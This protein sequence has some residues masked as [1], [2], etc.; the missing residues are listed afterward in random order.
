MISYIEIVT[1]ETYEMLCCMF[2]K[3]LRKILL[4]TLR[5]PKF[6]SLKEAGR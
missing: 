1:I 5:D 6:S 4:K 3:M 2:I